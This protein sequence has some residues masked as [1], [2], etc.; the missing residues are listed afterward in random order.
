MK[1]QTQR[2]DTRPR[3]V[4]SVAVVVTLYDAEGRVIGVRK[5]APE[6][7]TLPAGGRS[8]FEAIFLGLDEEV[9]SFAVQAQGL[10]VE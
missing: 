5:V 3:S 10:R 6:R 8:A 2:F 9:D 7:E 1:G 4:E